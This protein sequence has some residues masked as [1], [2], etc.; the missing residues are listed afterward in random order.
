MSK[1][2]NNLSVATPLN[3]GLNEITIKMS[4]SQENLSEG[5]RATKMLLATGPR[6]F[7]TS[8]AK[9]DS[10]AT[11][12]KTKTQQKK[13]IRPRT[14]VLPESNKSE[15]DLVNKRSTKSKP[16]RQLQYCNVPSCADDIA[17][18]RLYKRGSLDQYSQNEKNKM[19]DRK[20]E[21]KFDKLFESFSRRK[22]P[23]DPPTLGQRAAYSQ[24][25]Q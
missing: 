17:M 18:K 3:T 14:A 13:Q 10:L 16:R 4:H 22:D 20:L 7:S 24:P 1:T 23:I 19:F 9:I 2:Q 21:Q 11:V 5:K 8:Q 25:R 12:S 6:P 15:K